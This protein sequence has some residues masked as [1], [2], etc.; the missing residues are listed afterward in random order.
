MKLVRNFTGNVLKT[1][2]TVN[3]SG[4]K[5]HNLIKMK[6]D[7]LNVPSGL[8]VPTEVCNAY[9]TA[10]ATG[11]VEILDQV[12]EA[13]MIELTD[14]VWPES[15]HK[16]L[17]IRSGAPISM[18]GM[19]DTILNVGAGYEDKGLAPK[20]K[21]DCR[22]RFVE[23][24]ASVVMGHTKKI[25]NPVEWM[26]SIKKHI[27]EMREVIK[28]SIKA[29]WDSF[30]NERA[31]HY[32]KMNNI[33][34]DMGTAV[35][36]QSMVFGNYNSKSGSGVMFTRNP[37]TGEKRV[38]GDF[39]TNCQGEDV[40]A[41]TTTAP[42]I[43]DMQK[44]PGFK[45]L[46]KELV[47]I[48]EKL[49]AK[50]KDMQDIEFTIENGELFILQTRNG[51]RSAY[52]EIRIAL[53][54]LD[55]GLIDELGDRVNEGTFM[56]LRV[57]TLPEDF[58]MKPIAKG[59][60]SGG[61]F[62]TGKVAFGKDE[63]MNATEPCVLVAEET[64][65]D[66]IKAMEKAEGILTYKGSATCHAAVVAR[67]MNKP[68]VVG[69]ADSANH[70]MN[71]VLIDGQTGK[72]WFSDTAFDLEFNTN[73]PVELLGDLFEVAITE[74]DWIKVENYEE[75]LSLEDYIYKIG[76]PVHDLTGDELADLA[77]RFDKVIL[78]NP[79]RKDRISDFLGNANPE[80]MDNAR[81][82]DEVICNNPAMTN[83]FFDSG[84]WITDQVAKPYKTMADVMNPDFIGYIEK[85][86]VENVMGDQETF[87]KISEQLGL[88]AR[89]VD[90]ESALGL[91][92]KRINI[93]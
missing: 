22:R 58:N 35:V 30:D 47:K 37:S 67:G 13:V 65:P 33:P 57:P 25:E 21:K 87:E 11:Q 24:Y 43:S 59:I 40:V 54:L 85:G 7:G 41:G 56:K 27:P 36:I 60:G 93:G 16:L 61:Y 72:V 71:Y 15:E 5:G 6:L 84:N 12:I 91:L 14:N 66:D 29:V 80:E 26:K 78:L 73:I 79:E 42:P 18:P 19:M 8:V 53:D 64:T 23:M 10:T 89:V 46:Y 52:A 34:D 83:V 69:C 31:V 86:F 76:V 32:R 3:S 48:G 55:E 28:N 9:R 20:L 4:G 77:D 70:S 45:N 44:T 49:E 63:V 1:D 38:F 75:A 90:M 39:L 68:C 74:N 62:A 92:E 17:S 2:S 81:I 50:N 51:N 82:L 88:H